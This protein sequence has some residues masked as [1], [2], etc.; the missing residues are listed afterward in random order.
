MAGSAAYGKEGAAQLRQKKAPEGAVFVD[1][2]GIEKMNSTGGPVSAGATYY[3]APMFLGGTLY[4]HGLGAQGDS[5]VAI[6][7]KGAATRFMA[8]C[9]INED[10]KKG[11]GSVIF[12]IWL[13]GKKTQETAIMRGGEKPTLVSVDVT[14]VK[15]LYLVV[16]SAGD[17]VD[18][19]S[20]DWGGAIIYLAPGAKEMPEPLGIAQ[21][22]APQIA[23]TN[24]EEIGIHGPKAVGT[25]PGKPFVFL[26]PATGK[27]PIEYSAEGLPDGLALD[28]KT[29]VISGSLKENG[30]EMVRLKI[31]DASGAAAERILMI[32]GGP[33]RL[34][35]TPPMGWN[36][37]NVWGLAVDDAKVRQAADVMI[38]SGLAAHG[39]RF[40]NIDDGWE[41]DRGA[42]GKIVTNS[43]FP[44]MKSTSDYV[45]SKGLLFGIYSSPGA[46]TCGMYAGSLNHEKQD[47]DS[48]AGWGVDYLKYDWCSY[49]AVAKDQSLPEL[50]K[51]YEIM[52]DA[53]RASSRDIVYSLCQ[54]GMGNVWEWG[55]SVGGN[56]WR[57]TGDIVDTWGSMSGIGFSQLENGKYAGAGHWNDPDMLVV[58]R[59]GWGPNVHPT[60]LSPNEQITHITLWSML[61]APLLLGADMGSLDEFTVDLLTNDE[62][63]DIDQDILGKQATRVSKDGFY[64]VWSKPLHDGT[65]AVA[66][67]NRFFERGD[68]QVKWSDIGVTGRQPV[69]D[70][71]RKKNL[72]SFD[73]QY[74]ASVPAHGAVLLKIGAPKQRGH[75]H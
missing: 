34:A 60:R 54:Y 42:D 58:G 36:S 2:L 72:S 45:H 24:P 62:V 7:L 35:L 41:K 56:L 20:A 37:W 31:K 29:G 17:G 33:D 64:E 57:T 10:R 66:L 8:M 73:G 25:T 67:F 19:D 32:A 18:G 12:Q 4:T 38:S 28:S 50:K 44:D 30:S 74:T 59:V 1:T 46:F 71:W 11:Q 48:Y 22:P 39:F 55:A 75:T 15:R 43:K 70:L 9:G 27:Q 49:G 21:E 14:G 53:L 26:I 47:A 68:I 6:D 16:D 23:H 3:G 61:S 63:I 5:F 51:P 65:I 69:R 52:R 40:V 13:D